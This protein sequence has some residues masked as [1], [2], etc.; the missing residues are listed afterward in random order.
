MTLN[1]T[2]R[3]I[4]VGQGTKIN[5][6]YHVDS[7][8]SLTG[9][10]AQFWIRKKH[11]QERLIL[12]TADS[13]LQ[14]IGQEITGEL[15]DTTT[16]PSSDF[17][18]GDLIAD[19]HEYALEVSEAGQVQWRVKGYYSI[20]AERASSLDTEVLEQSITIELAADQTIT[21]NA[22]VTGTTGG[23]SGI[24]LDNSVSTPK[25]Q[26]LAVTEAKLADGSVTTPKLANDAV[27][28]LKIADDSI[29]NAKI[30]VNAITEDK[31]LNSAISNAKLAANAV[32]NEKVLDNTISYQKLASEILRQI[33]ALT[34]SDGDS[35]GWQAGVVANLA[36]MLKADYDTNDDGIVDA[37]DNAITANSATTAGIASSAPWSGITGTPND[38]VGYGITDG[39][40]STT[41]NTHTAL[42]GNGAHIPSSGLSIG[43]LTGDVPLD[44]IEAIPASNVV[45]NLTAGTASPTATTVAALKSAF[46]LTKAD[47][48]LNNV[49]NID[50]TNASNITSGVLLDAR[51]SSAVTKLG[52][53]VN[54]GSGLVQLVTGKIPGALIDIGTIPGLGALAELDTVD[55]DQ[56]DDEA[57]T[58]AKI[59]NLNITEEK[60][61]TH[62]VTTGKIADEAVNNAKIATDADIDISKLQDI[63]TNTIL[64]NPAGASAPP[65]AANNTQ[66]KSLLQISTSDLTDGGNLAK[67]D[68]ANT[69]TNNQ[70]I[71]N[72]TL[73]ASLFLKPGDGTPNERAFRI[74]STSGDLEFLATADNGNTPV[75]RFK[76]DHQ[77]DSISI[78]S[79]AIDV[80]TPQ[81]VEQNTIRVLADP[82]NIGVFEQVDLTIPTGGE[83]VNSFNY[84]FSTATTDA[85]PGNGKV[86][87]N[88]A[89]LTLA[90][91]IFINKM[92]D[93]DNSRFVYLLGLE[94]GDRCGIQA[95]DDTSNIDVYNVTG[96][97][98]D[99]STYV[100]IPVAFNQGNGTGFSNNEKVLFFVGYGANLT[101][102]NISG[103]LSVAK[104]GTGA[105]DAATARTNLGAL[106][107]AASDGVLYGRLNGNWVEVNIINALTETVNIIPGTDAI[108]AALDYVKTKALGSG[109][110]VTIQAA[111]GSYTNTAA[112]QINFPGSNHV[113]IRGGGAGTIFNFSGTQG[114]T[115]DEGA[116]LDIDN[117]TIQGD[118]TGDF[119][120]TGIGAFRDC[121]ILIG[122]G[123]V[124][125][126][127]FSYGT[128][129]LENA[130][131]IVN[132]TISNCG[133]GA[134]YINRCIVDGRNATI[135]ASNGS[136]WIY[137]AFGS[138]QYLGTVAT[139]GEIQ[140]IE[141]LIVGATTTINCE[142]YNY[143]LAEM[144][145]DQDTTLALSNTQNGLVV[146]MTV[147]STG[148][149]EL[150]FSGAGLPGFTDP[151]KSSPLAI[152]ASEVYEIS[153]FRKE[154][155][156]IV[157]YGLLS[158]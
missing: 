58:T 28:T 117:C 44:S 53:V 105:T 77:N 32:T 158:F 24:P 40:N 114:F 9:K 75:S 147:G 50:T 109:T 17:T 42:E 115:V 104:G 100:K 39:V 87:F 36:T 139:H 128:G 47:V 151:S 142:G 35:I 141:P 38:L 150:D 45:A 125:D 124:I 85:N 7:T 97:P 22:P 89:N 55:T 1:Q 111:V 4:S 121:K 2:T 54:T 82:A 48:G 155:V 37:A 136:P 120:S 5:L 70:S 140:N 11:T 123:V 132:G 86:S 112:V 31:V 23:G 94:I 79:V 101:L 15:I 146:H 19:N 103:V 33:A 72:A 90:T 18:Y 81:A 83:G 46:A 149:F 143:I 98:V 57:V 154:G 92:D 91:F 118:G 116:T 52:N 144:T 153:L 156:I 110:I 61:D 13:T 95:K 84:R 93:D 34:A 113:R 80:S 135:A 145:L 12:D 65:I 138:G 126:N 67:L 14:I 41:F 27:N 6:V 99:A 56:I 131:I 88:N 30:T 25:I 106:G 148:S 122:S 64:A 3:D 29:T 26:D 63:A 51:L 21:I 20:K 96:T 8:Y 129:A 16:T 69:F 66:V 68:T 102:G 62:A 60:I 73:A 119:T 76:I 108:T 10:A 43:D 71:E 74:E 152:E 107:D 133:V 49:P 137:N 127:F 157:E 134:V 130:F 78:G 59:P